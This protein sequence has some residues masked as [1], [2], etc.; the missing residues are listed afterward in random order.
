MGGLPCFTG[1]GNR[2]VV[3]F[4]LAQLGQVMCSLFVDSSSQGGTY[5]DL[6]PANPERDGNDGSTKSADGTL[7]TQ[8]WVRLI[9]CQV[10]L[11]WSRRPH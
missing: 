10:W 11:A 4:A 8:A 5:P 6:A 7:A 9:A 3:S 2:M 1:F